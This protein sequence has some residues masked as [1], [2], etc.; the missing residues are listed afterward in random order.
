MSYTSQ[1]W[2]VAITNLLKKTSNEE[3]TWQL[4]ELFKGDAWTEVDRSFECLIGDKYY[5][6]SQTKRKHFIDEEEF[7]WEQGYNFSV[8]KHSFDVDLI[9]SAP[10]ELSIIRNLFDA[11]GKSYAFESDALGDLLN[12]P[13]V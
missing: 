9:A 11:A 13:N 2:R 4:S 5:V 1:D 6:V 7:F 3:I 12:G 10:E 8:F